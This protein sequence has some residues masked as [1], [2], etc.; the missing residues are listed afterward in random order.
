MTGPCPSCGAT[1]RPNDSWCTLCF[2]DL[3]PPPPPPPAPPVVAAA[4]VAGRAAGVAPGLDPF[5]APLDLLPPLPPPPPAPVDPLT[6]PLNA[7][8]SQPLTADPGAPAPTWPCVECGERSPLDADACVVCLTP[9]GG[10]IARLDDAKALRQ[11]RMFVGI[12]AVVAFL[13]LL[14]V[15]SMATTKSPPPQD[16]GPVVT[17]PE[18]PQ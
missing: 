10:R 1:V 9:F 14:A 3:R 17:V 2:A 6:A 18:L 7:V 4:P 11:R 8:L 5:T 16:P 12:G 15:F 13:T